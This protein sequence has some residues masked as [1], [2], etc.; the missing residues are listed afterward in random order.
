MSRFRFVSDDDGHNY[1]IPAELDIKFDEMLEDG[2]DDYYAEFNNT[3][4]KYRCDSVSNWTFEN[5]KEE[6]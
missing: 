1:L 5:P 4:S 6:Y 3:F 2:E